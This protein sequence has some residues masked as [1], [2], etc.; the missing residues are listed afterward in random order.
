[1]PR[2][3]PGKSAAPV[4]PGKPRTRSNVNTHLPSTRAYLQLGTKVPGVVPSS[5]TA[6]RAMSVPARTGTTYLR[7]D[8][9]GTDEVH[10]LAQGNGREDQVHPVPGVHHPGRV[11]RAGVRAGGAGHGRR[12]D[13]RCA[14]RSTGTRTQSLSIPRMRSTAARPSSMKSSGCGSSTSR[15]PSRSKTGEQFL[16]RPPELGL[17]GRGRLGPAVELRVHRVH[18][19]IR[20]DLD[21][22]FPVAHRGLALA[23]VRA[24]GER[25][26]RP[27]R[28]GHSSP[29]PRLRR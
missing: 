2:R 3:P 1:M 6:M 22:P 13:E 28:H 17:A 21:G 12:P 19:E 29:M 9:G 7:A 24:V 26:C 15:M 10:E 18:A 25:V 4:I 27:G 16:H 14:A 23:G 8:A 20:R 11:P 5:S